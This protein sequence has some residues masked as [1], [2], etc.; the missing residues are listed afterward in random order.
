MPNRDSE[1]YLNRGKRPPSPLVSHIKSGTPFPQY[2]YD[3]L[4]G[5]IQN[6]NAGT[7]LTVCVEGKE[8]PINTV[9]QLNQYIKR[10][11]DGYFTLEAPLTFRQFENVDHTEV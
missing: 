1:F 10:K 4:V 5:F 8:V 6:F 7:L 11:P 9:D 3:S 2:T